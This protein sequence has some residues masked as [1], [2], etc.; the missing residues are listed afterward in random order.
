[1]MVG[2]EVLLRVQKA[3]KNPGEV[4]FE[5]S[6]LSVAS[7]NGTR[8]VSHLSLKVHAGEIL[9]IAG[10]SGNGQTEL[11]EAITACGQWMEDNYSSWAGM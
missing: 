11:V 6:D 3:E 4:V 7:A 1:M 9:G 10:V 8:A 2:R 5:A